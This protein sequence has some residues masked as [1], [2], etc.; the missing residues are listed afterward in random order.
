MRRLKIL[1]LRHMIYWCV[2]KLRELR[3][4]VGVY[5]TTLNNEII[6]IEK[7]GGEE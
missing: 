5:Y 1:L 2:D 6:I 3:V 4:E 7:G